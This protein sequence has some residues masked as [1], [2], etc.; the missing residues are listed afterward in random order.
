MY[1]RIKIRICGRIPHIPYAKLRIFKSAFYILVVHNHKYTLAL[2]HAASVGPP[3]VIVPDLSDSG[4][5]TLW[6]LATVAIFHLRFDNQ[7][8]KVRPERRS[9]GGALI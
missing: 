4:P 8:S 7:T 2:R 9:R 3:I 5:P 1:Y 6:I